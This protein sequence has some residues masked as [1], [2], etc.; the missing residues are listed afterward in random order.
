MARL[1]DGAKIPYM[2]IG[3]QAVLVHGEPRLTLDVDVTLGVG[4]EK[5]DHILSLIS[6]E[7]LAPIPEDPAGFARQTLVLPARDAKS[8]ERVDIIF[9]D[10]PYEHQ[11]IGR[12]VRLSIAG[13]RVCF[14]S[15]E[16]LLIHKLIAARPRDLEDARGIWL[17]QKSRLDAAYVERWLKEFSALPGLEK[18]SDLWRQVRAVS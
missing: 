8:G 2:V 11:A 17:R 16:D 14:A 3:G 10:T 13:T 12:A 18:I 9:S 7:G 5:L 1:L 6:R 15:P 4:T